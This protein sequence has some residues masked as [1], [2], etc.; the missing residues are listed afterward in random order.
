MKASAGAR[1]HKGPSGRA[2]RVAAFGVQ[3]GR[4]FGK[5]L[6]LRGDDLAGRGQ[7]DVAHLLAGGL[8]A[9]LE[10][11]QRRAAPESRTSRGPCAP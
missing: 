10:V 4:G 9:R 8:D 2:R 3:P 5:A 6:D 11:A 1:V 7:L